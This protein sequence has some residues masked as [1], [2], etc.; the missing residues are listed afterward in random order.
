[1]TKS[2]SALHIITFAVPFPTNYGGAID[3]WNRI[4]ALHAAGVEIKLHC[5]LYGA[6]RSHVIIHEFVQEVH[7]YP[8]VVWPALFSK[9]QPYIVSSRRS[10]PLLKRLM[11][12]NLPILFDGIHTTGF[13]NELKGRTRLLRAH[14]VEHAYYSQLA[15]DAKGVKSLVFNREALCLRDYESTFAKEFDAVFAISPNDYSWF[16][17]HGAK[18]ILMPPFHGTR[19][20]DVRTG[21][22]D[23]ILYQGDLSI[24]IN[25][26]AL[27]DMLS[28]IP[29]TIQYPIVV[30]GRAGHKV[31]EDK[32]SKYVNIQ[33]E[34]DVSEEKMIELVRNAQLVIIHSLHQAGMKL[35][36][37]TALFHGRFILASENSKTNT[38]LDRGITYYSPGALGSLIEQFW[39]RAFEPADVEQRREILQAHPNDLE[40]AKEILRY[41]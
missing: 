24:E 21:H 4:V 31:F 33:R 13:F 5:F 41:L 3:A 40:M 2:T 6:F 12:D 20:V 23:Y 1:M 27:F 17:N 36:I 29:K 26:A 18:A 28:A 30:A 34:A 32:L 9:G 10:R 25:Q 7:Y 35:K 16:A 15:E 38:P 39:S 22:G 37:F 11:Q 8:R 19:Q 14:N